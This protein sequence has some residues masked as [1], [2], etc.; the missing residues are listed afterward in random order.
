MIRFVRRVLEDLKRGENID[1]VVAVILALIISLLNALGV[2]PSGLVLSATLATLGLIAIG[3][4]ITRYRIEDILSK[5]ETSNTVLFL[6]EK[7]PFLKSIMASATEIWMVGLTL[8]TT[9]TENYYVLKQGVREGTKIRTLIVDQNKLNMSKVVRRFSRAATEEHFNADFMQTVSQYKSIC[10]SADNSGNIPLRL[11]DFVPSC[12][13]YIFP[14]TENGGV[15][16]AEMYGYKSSL[17]SI[18]RFQLNEYDNPQWYRFFVD[19][20]EQMWHDAESVDLC[21]TATA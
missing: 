18:P 6:K 15:V 2:A 13:L 21:S 5:G 14:K 11:L 19:Q 8:R 9:T 7:P 10:E 16:F 4:L 3:F 17:G 20:F 1:L 12:S